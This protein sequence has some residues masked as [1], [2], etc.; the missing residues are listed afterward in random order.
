MPTLDEIVAYCDRRTRRSAFQD[1]PGAANGLQVANNGRVTKSAP[2]LM[3]AS[4]RLRRPRRLVW[5]F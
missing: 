4:Y 2:Q 1:Y 3:P 5:I